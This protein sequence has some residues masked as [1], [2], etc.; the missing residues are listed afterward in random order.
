TVKGEFISA[1]DSGLILRGEDGRLGRSI[2]WFKLTQESLKKLEGHPKA[3][4]YVELLIE[5]PPG[6]E[7]P[8]TPP[9]ITLKEPPKPPRRVSPL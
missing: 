6:Q 8:M 9:P 5:P 4:K 3:G 1:S 2:T 7:P